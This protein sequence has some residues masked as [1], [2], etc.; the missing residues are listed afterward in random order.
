MPSSF[1]TF[2]KYIPLAKPE[3]SMVVLFSFAGFGFIAA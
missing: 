3:I 2:T 1:F